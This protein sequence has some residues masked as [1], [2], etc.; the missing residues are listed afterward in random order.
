MNVKDCYDNLT[1][2]SID[3]VK[4]FLSIPSQI[5]TAQLPCKYVK[6]NISTY[7]VA[8]LNG[9]HGLANHSFD[10]VCLVEPIG[11]NNNI[12]NQTLVLNIISSLGDYFN[13]L[14]DVISLETSNQVILINNVPYWGFVTTVVFI[15]E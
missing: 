4:S 11:Q 1:N 10:I 8:S 2:T 12:Q 6:H 13:N 7:G 5:N 15:G 14:A 3:G 9:S